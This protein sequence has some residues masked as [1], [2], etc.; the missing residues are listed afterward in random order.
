MY[1]MYITYYGQ[2]YCAQ[3]NEL[4]IDWL[5]SITEHKKQFNMFS[6]P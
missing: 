5:H 3:D 6:T 1:T 2:W 4:T